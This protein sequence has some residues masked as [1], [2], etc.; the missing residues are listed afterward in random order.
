MKYCRG[1]VVITGI[2]RETEPQIRINS[3]KSGV[4]QSVRVQLGVQPDAAA[5]MPA[6]VDDDTE[7]LSRDLLHRGVELLAA[8]APP[9]SEGVTGEA[10]GVHPNQGDMAV[11]A[12]AVQVTQN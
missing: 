12:I 7:A 9:R 5:L 4:L 11:P 10:L 8:V 2:D 6:K 1:H 3:V